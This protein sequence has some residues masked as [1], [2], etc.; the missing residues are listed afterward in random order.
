[1]A[2]AS[3][4][5]RLGLAAVLFL[6]AAAPA[7][8]ALPSRNLLG[9]PD[10]EDGAPGAP[11]ST[12]VITPLNWSP[13]YDWSKLIT[14]VRY[15]AIGG[16]PT[17]AQ[18]VALNGGDNFIA[19]GPPCEPFSAPGCQDNPRYIR[20]NFLMDGEYGAVA[21]LTG[22]LGGFA[23]QDDSVDVKA[24]L[25]GPVDTEAIIELKG[26]SAEERGGETEL[27]PRA[28][29]VVVP[30]NVDNVVVDLTFNRASGQGTYSDGYADNLGFWLTP[31]GAPVPAPDCGTPVG[32]PGGGGGAGN[33]GGGG[34]GG[35]GG[36]GGT[37]PVSSPSLVTAAAS[38]ARLNGARS[39]VG[40]PL[41]CN[42]HDVPCAGTLRLTASSLKLGSASFSIPAGGRR[43]VQVRLSRS[44]KRRLARLPS[45]RLRRLRLTG[46]VTIG[47]ASSSFGLKLSG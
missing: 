18:G 40:V 14:E 34:N 3:M 43:V 26:P 47:S 23:D 8:A 15:G 36:G 39:K 25:N 35:G 30:P 7:A 27:L 10:F 29:S 31:N 16:F 46:T 22:C 11:D 42:A 1:M 5:K 17:V 45:R 28:A 19:G 24:F 37:T 20:Q 33:T 38:S 44:V 21:T 2:L 9:N 41:S 32:G 13:G 12:H 4:A 6:V